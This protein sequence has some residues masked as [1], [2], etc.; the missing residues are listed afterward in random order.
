LGR[1][2]GERG[3]FPIGLSSEAIAAICR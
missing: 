1:T 2:V 3:F